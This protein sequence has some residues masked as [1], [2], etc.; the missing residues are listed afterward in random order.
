MQ[1]PVRLASCGLEVS[2][3]G[4]RHVGQELL[5]TG[6]RTSLLACKA[7]AVADIED[8]GIQVVEVVQSLRARNV[9]DVGDDSERPPVVDLVHQQPQC[10]PLVAPSL[11]PIGDQREH[12]G[13]DRSHHGSNDRDPEVRPECV[14]HPVIRSLAE[15]PYVSSN[16]RPD[17]QLPRAA[18]REDVAAASSTVLAHAS[19]VMPT[20][21]RTERSSG[22]CYPIRPQVTNESYETFGSYTPRGLPPSCDLGT[23]PLAITTPLTTTPGRNVTNS[24]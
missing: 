10:L 24:H 22:S 16:A 14:P 2:V 21:T 3:A 4:P 8:A 1:V 18:K 9:Y 19:K 15:H 23:L 5:G 7:N 6:L 17:H 11:Q 20:G 12:H 13:Q